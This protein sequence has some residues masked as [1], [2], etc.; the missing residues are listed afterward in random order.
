MSSPDPG[1]SSSS[2]GSIFGQ[3][4]SGV[5]NANNSLAVKGVAQVKDYLAKLSGLRVFVPEASGVGHQ[6]SSVIVLNQLI[7]LGCPA[8]INIAYEPNAEANLM[9]LLPGWQG[10]SST[11]GYKGKTLT[12][13]PFSPGTTQLAEADLCVTGAMDYDAK[14]APNPAADNL[15]NAKVF[16]Q[17][18]PFGWEYQS[19]D[20]ALNQIWFKGNGKPTRLSQ[21]AMGTD[22]DKLAF[23]MPDPAPD[24]IDWTV[25]QQGLTDQV[26]QQALVMAQEISTFVTGAKATFLP[27]YGLLL[28]D[29]SRQP[30][31]FNPV[32]AAMTLLASV[33]TY[34]DKVDGRPAVVVLIGRP[35]SW[36]WDFV[37]IAL[38]Q[39]DENEDY[40]EFAWRMEAKDLASILAGRVT[41]SITHSADE[42]QQQLASL[43]SQKI[44]LVWLR[45]V[46]PAVFELLM[47]QA[48]LPFIFEGQATANL[49][50]NLGKP[51]LKLAKY[52]SDALRDV[53]Y[54]APLM[55]K[56][57]WDHVNLSVANT[58]R[59]LCQNGLYTA[60]EW[61]D[62]VSGV[63]PGFKGYER[64]LHYCSS[65]RSSYH[66]NEY[67]KLVLAVRYL[68]TL[69]S[70]GGLK[71]EP[72]R[73]ELAAPAGASPLQTLYSALLANSSG[74]TVNVY[75][76]AIAAGSEPI[77]TALA[78]LFGAGGLRVAGTPA[79]PAPSTEVS[80]TGP[81]T[82]WLGVTLDA[83]LQ[84]TLD[85][86]GQ[87]LLM[88]LSLTG[89]TLPFDGVPWFAVDKPTVTVDVSN[90]GIRIGGSVSGEVSLGDTVVALSGDMPAIST[91]ALHAD[92]TQNPPSLESVFQF[93]GGVNLASYLPSPLNALAG[94]SL[95][96]LSF[97]YDFGEKKIA[98]MTVT[99]EATPGWNLVG[100]L[101]LQ[102][103]DLA[104]TVIDPAG[105]RTIAWDATSAFTLGSG[106]IDIL[107][108]YPDTT[109]T[110]SLAAQGNPIALTDL[111]TCFLGGSTSLPVSGDLSALTLTLVPGPPA[112]YQLDVGVTGS[113]PVPTS[114]LTVF[115]VE[116]LGF[117]I[118]GLQSPARVSISGSVT[119]FASDPSL[120]FGLDVS[121]ANSDPDGA[122]VITGQQNDSP[123]KVTDILQHY[124]PAGWLASELPDF[125][126]TGFSAEIH[127]GSAAPGPRYI[128]GG[129]VDAFSI[130]ILD[131]TIEATASFGNLMR[132]GGETSAVTA[133]AQDDAPALPFGHISAE[134]QWHG[135]TLDAG[136]DYA[137]DTQSYQITWEG[138]TAALKQQPVDGTEHWIA[139]VTL[140]DST[141]LGSMV[142]TFV[143]WVTGYRFGLAAPWNL[144]D[145]ISLSGLVL[146]YDFTAGSVSFT[147]NVGPI[148]LGFCT[149]TGVGLT[150]N[151]SPGPNDHKVAVVID[152]SFAWTGGGNLSWDATDPNST[153]A[154]PGGGN[155]YFYLRLL[156][157]G[158]HVTVPG[159]S[160][161]QTV[162]DAIAALAALAAP[163]GQNAPPVPY[164]ATSSWLVGTDFGVMKYDQNAGDY[165]VTLQ[166]VFA[167]PDLYGLRLALAGEPAKILA[168]LDFEVLYRKISDTIGVY[169]AQI[170]LPTAMR[171]FQAGV[172][173]IG[174]PV[175]AVAVY[176]NGDFQI[177]FGFPWNGDF[178]RSFALQ[179]IVP[180]G[181]PLTGA[182]GFYFGKLSSA[183]SDKVPAVTNGTFDPV[184]VFGVGVNAGVGKSVEYGPLSASLSIVV[185]AIIEGVVARW[186]PYSAADGGSTTPSQLDG[187]FYYS[188]SGTFG[189]AGQLSGSVDFAVIKAS[190]NV[191]VVVTAQI[192]L[193]AYEPIVF[194]V[195]ASVDVSASLSI[196]LGI[197]SITISFQFSLTVSESFEIQSPS[198][199]QAPWT[200]AAPAAQGRL[201]APLVERLTSMRL[202]R[203]LI[204]PA[205][206]PAWANLTAPASPAALDGYLTYALTAAGDAATTLA[207]QQAC[208]VALLTLDAPALD[209]G[210]ATGTSDTATTS[211]EALCGLVATWVI[212]AYGGQAA[213]AGQ[214][215]A[216]VV[217][218][219]QLKAILDDLTTPGVTQPIPLDAVEAMLGQ[220]VRL[221]IHGLADAGGSQASVTGTVFPMPP[222]L[223]FTV[224][225]CGTFPGYDYSFGTYNTISAS[226]I[227][228]LQQYLGQLASQPPAA[229]AQDTASMSVAGFVFADYFLLIA[230]HM[231]T[232]LREGLRDYKYAVPASRQPQDV[233]TWVN[234]TGQITDPGKQFTLADLLAANPGVSTGPDGSFP[235]GTVLDLPH[236]PQ[237]PVSAL[238]AEAQQT[239]AVAQLAAMASRFQLHGLRLPTADI[240]PNHPGMWVT[241]NGGTLS[242]PPVAGLY[243]LTGQQVPL[244]AP[245]TEPFSLTVSNPAGSGWLQFAD[246]TA[247]TTFTVTPGDASAGA[248]TAMQSWITQNRLVTGTACLGAAAALCAMPTSSSFG[249][250]IGWISAAL[251]SLPSGSPTAGA[252]SARIWPLPAGL[253][254]LLDHD[255]HAVSPQFIVETQTY[256]QATG[257][258]ASAPIVNYGWASLIEFTVQQVPGS[259][260]TYQVAGVAAADTVLLEDL[261]AQFQ[262][263]GQFAGV[264][265]G[266][267]P[268]ASPPASGLQ[269]GSTAAAFGIGQADLSTQTQPGTSQTAMAMAAATAPPAGPAALNG[270]ATFLR[271]L[272]EAAIT[273]SSGFYLCYSDGGS[274]LPGSVFDNDGKA[275][276]T[277][278]V[279]Y[280]TEVSGVADC[281]NAYVATDPVDTSQSAVVATAVPQAVTV[282]PAATDTLGGLAASYYA[283]LGQLAEDNPAAAL[284]AGAVLAVNTGTYMVSPLGTA[285][286]GALDAIAAYFGVSA[287]AISAAN[288]GVAG[289]A[290]LPPY[291]AIRLPAITVT[292]GTSAGGSTLGSIAAYYGTDV[293]SL[294]AD[295]QDTPGLF[296]GPLAVT[297][298]PTVTS[299]A[300]PAG[301]QP[302]RLQRPVPSLSQS[303]PPSPPPADPQSVLLNQFSLLGYQI[304]ANQDFA[305]SNLGVPVGP[306]GGGSGVGKMR[307]PSALAEGD[308]WRYDVTLRYD[309]LASGGADSPYD[310]IGRLLQV[311]F[312]WVDM[313][314]NTLITDLSDP[315]PGDAG[316]LN[317]IPVL[318]GYT[319]PLIAVSQWPSVT[320]Q[321]SVTGA[322]GA[323]QLTVELD[324]DTTRYTGTDANAAHA[325]ADLAV[326]TTVAAQLADPNGVTVTVETS[327]S[328]AP[329][330]AGPGSL[331]SWTGSIKTYLASVA[332][333][334]AGTAP[335]PSAAFS[336][337]LAATLNPAE[338]FELTCAIVLSR[339]GGRPQ[340]AFAAVPGVS[341]VSTTVTPKGMASARGL[342]AFASDFETALTSP[343]S[344]LK[345]A[346]GPNRF[347]GGAASPATL[348]AVRVGLAGTDAIGYVVTDPAAP[349]IFAP[350]PISTQLVSE[351]NV[352]ISPYVSGVGIG[353]PS[354]QN[355]AGVDLDQWARTIFAAVD[356]IMTPQNLSALV[357][358]DYLTSGSNL[359]TLQANKALLA[360]MYARQMQPVFA[361]QASAGS[362]TASGLLRQ[363]MLRQLGNAYATQAA[364]QFDADVVAD[365]TEVPASAEPPSLYGTVVQ[366]GTP[367]PGVAFGAARL[368]LATATGVPVAFLV[369]TP[370]QTA[371]FTASSALSVDLSYQPSLIEHQIGPVPGITAYSAS[372][373]LSFVTAL[374]SGSTGQL[375]TV[376]IPMVLRTYPASPALVSQTGTATNPGATDVASLSEWTYAF[377]YTLPAHYPQDTVHAAVVFNVAQGLAA[378]ALLADSFAAMAQ[379]VSVFPDVQPDLSGALAQLTPSLTSTSPAVTTAAIAIGA[380]NDMLDAITG[381]A[382][383]GDSAAAPRPRFTVRDRASSLVSATETTWASSVRE[384][385]GTVGTT[386]GALIVTVLPTSGP[387]PEVQIA[388][389]A[390]QR[391]TEGSPPAGG[392]Q[393]TYADDAGNVL[394]F[395][396]AQIMGPRLVVYPGLPV[397]GQQDALTTVYVARNENLVDGRPTSGSFIYRTPDVAFSSPLQPTLT[398]SV[399]IDLASVGSDSPA[400]R[401]LDGHLTALFGALAGPGLPPQVELQIAITYS[402]T[403]NPQRG[404]PPLTVSVPVLFQPPTTVAWQDGGGPT[405]VAD[406]VSQL[407]AA[408]GVWFGATSPS[409]SDGTFHFDLTITSHLT[410][411]TMPLLRLTSLSVQL[412][413]VNPA[414]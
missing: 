118:N 297:A 52:Q 167:D 78:E 99:L 253:T 406:M 56:S 233:V 396:D 33:A 196:D 263:D 66:D 45:G 200:V 117:S 115:T 160:G 390:A 375:G 124:L 335:A 82:S 81:T 53:I 350:A 220:Q 400:T 50:L 250:P 5:T 57:V 326:Y 12:F 144:L 218:D 130:P 254:A 414:P 90:A 291:T 140:S 169:Q 315:Q 71:Q 362:G 19:R 333:G 36:F 11:L 356:A 193:T 266:F 230:R 20:D 337:P 145:D 77:P 273:A 276:L 41:L 148:E 21:K 10:G 150:Y 274:G 363:A 126:I 408:V 264:W 121:A 252:T 204:T 386:A 168:G 232:T 265:I 316:P 30:V 284:V 182:G 86:G 248:I 54:A 336:F 88:T 352:G 376:D 125:E 272:W 123:V 165:A 247:S 305:A 221:A 93:I 155:E 239:G 47:S 379:F 7:A 249:P 257:T 312:S 103:V 131:G 255:T 39:E 364:L 343:S 288:P 184:I 199:G 163:S 183:T 296:A 328:T 287:A 397:I 251:P 267:P 314:G 185:L 198:T 413:Y 320:S 361:G 116:S 382:G 235:A 32:A 191:S 410:A 137:P 259:T 171:T 369:T 215:A 373:W 368:P 258:T 227:A 60:Q 1:G 231:V 157:M 175:I 371:G 217:T 166:V 346:A 105:A 302:Y 283:D 354:S 201:A 195:A 177:D 173:T 63:F 331:T 392:S 8:S 34:Q 188:V 330:P 6:A 244:P 174:L 301:S 179:G 286:G 359:A 109:V 132:A 143:S 104:F 389:Y 70:A 411:Q 142:E 161:A 341:T 100:S 393:Y 59:A 24:Q 85:T 351:A 401:P 403:V 29:N 110:A 136:Y 58:A 213:S 76:G 208:Y 133:A 365:V 293:V 15:L 35:K 91:F 366:N 357:I 128:I 89:P 187:T 51:F 279:I 300:L 256:D 111:V 64:L 101:A 388:G 290:A 87:T 242:L 67:D 162:Q 285:P 240:T 141:T 399:P 178:T 384:D 262:S 261:V 277:L 153:P 212:A 236:L 355:F 306:V 154:P 210:T 289:S 345:V 146:T 319:D 83:S 292:V 229:P 324:F 49:A 189:I 139:D 190:V 197:F 134:I 299:S 112:R 348:W 73:V 270:N 74:G 75:P 48:T 28:P 80:L 149:I 268:D 98:S 202:A 338:L 325:Q 4:L 44:L 62:A 96:G 16:L 158:Q 159:I 186:N 97:A 398:S 43:G 206:E 342:Q 114:A 147:V 180:P 318:L 405:T 280:S 3:A 84:F 181:I 374:P 391:Y 332:Q 9:L 395:A 61:V 113:W 176:T 135:I 23:N 172:F 226:G 377:T 17:L 311:E 119:F 40:S 241:G 246:G 407:S 68:L 122:W 383:T 69:P 385:S 211:F 216:S 95:K 2:P 79:F 164:D 222:D 13:T 42:L 308:M 298:G 370:A 129:T 344:V 219:D 237:F 303:P 294:A 102:T 234:Q 14:L 224:P 269:T 358:L 138:L 353:S 313:F 412:A 225:A 25:I 55:E 120:A 360:A 65:L 31:C 238:L 203:G 72:E 339:T 205:A 243:A 334:I 152:G 107:V 404:I 207:G 394:L 22:F 329:F 194:T 304:A 322:A 282:T 223:S 367:V 209:A 260:N 278:I 18:Q 307:R 402:Y 228:S 347:E 275:A 245:V 271:L 295:N 380:V 192:V 37:K 387:V 281:M 372:T 378:E 156:A 409:Q 26:A 108:S 38:G 310:A 214:V 151:T 327:L 349:V 317:R 92:L 127:A 381:R 309:A 106:E 46:P 323:A 94:V 170:A 27:C 340:G 321:W